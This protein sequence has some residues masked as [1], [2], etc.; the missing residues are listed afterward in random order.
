MEA[1]AQYRR[2][3]ELLARS[4]VKSIG[5]EISVLRNYAK[6]KR[7]A[8]DEIGA[9]ELERRVDVLMEELGFEQTTEIETGR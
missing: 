1:E 9:T 5:S 2:A 3:L 6:L 7:E 4:D 8:G